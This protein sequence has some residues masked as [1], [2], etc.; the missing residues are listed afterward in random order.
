MSNNN[1]NNNNDS[2]YNQLIVYTCTTG[3]NAVRDVDTIGPRVCHPQNWK[4]SWKIC[5]AIGIFWL[6]NF[7]TQVFSA[8]LGNFGHF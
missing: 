4:G 6:L 2:K 5:V 3:N 1:N 7:P 8:L